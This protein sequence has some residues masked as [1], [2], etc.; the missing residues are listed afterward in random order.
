[1][2]ELT[3]EQKAK[4]YDEL[5]VK[6]KQIYNKENDVLIMYT[7]EDLFPE[8]KESEG[9]KVRKAL[10]D[11]FG[12]SA[13][14]GGQTNGVYDKNILAWLEKQTEQKLAWG[15]EDERKRKLIIGL[16][17]GWLSTFK[18][19]CY[20]EDCKCG[21]DWLKSLRPQ[22]NITDE[23]LAQAKKNAYNDALDKIEYHSDEPTFDDGWSAAIDYIRK[24]SLRPHN[25]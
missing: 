15:E 3:I 11:F 1:M 9:E 24:K 17:E 23:E 4:A 19:T 25:R 8:L 21:I 18:E 22:N 12:K 2:K 16:L 13:K 5:L 10:I 14:Y 6:A 20:A 7:I